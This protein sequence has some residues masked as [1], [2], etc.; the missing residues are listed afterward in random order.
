[1]IKIYTWNIYKIEIKKNSLIIIEMIVY[2][3]NMCIFKIGKRNGGNLLEN[4][5]VIAKF[6]CCISMRNI[7]F[8]I[9]ILRIQ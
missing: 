9:L 5:L 4:L 6:V 3:L 8:P 7:F 1:M 2:I